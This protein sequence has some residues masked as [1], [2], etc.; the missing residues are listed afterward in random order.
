MR[1][2]IAPMLSLWSA[3]ALAAEPAPLPVVDVSVFSAWRAEARA[4]LDGI[5]GGCEARLP[6]AGVSFPITLHVL[7]DGALASPWGVDAAAGSRGALGPSSTWIGP[8]G[9]HYMPSERARAAPAAGDFVRCFSAGLAALHLAP[10]PGGRAIRLHYTVTTPVPPA[11]RGNLPA[12]R[13]EPPEFDLF[14]PDGLENQIAA[15]QEIWSH[16][17]EVIACLPPQSP[18]VTVRWAVMVGGPVSSVSVLSDSLDDDRR[19]CVEDRIMRWMFPDPRG[20]GLRYVVRYTFD[21]AVI[22]PLGVPAMVDGSMARPEPAPSGA[23]P[24]Q[25][26]LLTIDALVAWRAELRL[27]VDQSRLACETQPPGAASSFRLQLHLLPDGGQDVGSSTPGAGASPLAA[28]LVARLSAARLPPPP[29]GRGLNLELLVMTRAPGDSSAPEEP[30]LVEPPRFDPITPASV[31]LKLTY[32]RRIWSREDEAF[33]CLPPR[34]PPVPATWTVAHDGSVGEIRGLPDALTD[35]QRRCVEGAISG[36]RFP[37]P[38]GDSGALK[39]IYTFDP[40]TR[41]PIGDAEP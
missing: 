2:M 5:R 36:W 11:L 22:A 28:C 1:P 16:E 12:L 40:V 9:T 27:A 41:A 10:P 18:P 20:D 4:A 15:A 34:S 19:R 30:I 21:P 23:L 31:E 6:D 8:L 26:P 3:A 7:P 37:V 13:Y 14:A 39:V 33:N 24:A 35:E 38:P 17:A 29:G 32:V 25:V